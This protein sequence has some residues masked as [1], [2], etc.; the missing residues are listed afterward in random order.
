MRKT[1]ALP[2]NESWLGASARTV[3]Q[4][5]PG[6]TIVVHSQAQRNFIE[7]EL[8]Y[9]GKQGVR[10]VNTRQRRPGARWW[11]TSDP[12]EDVDRVYT[13]LQTQAQA[14]RSKI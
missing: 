6:D 13:W 9:A 3:A 11:E 1:F 12:G 4:A 8:A 14:A 10:M 7:R 2:M 5:C